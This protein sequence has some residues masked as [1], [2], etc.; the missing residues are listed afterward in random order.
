MGRGKQP[1]IP[2]LG[3]AQGTLEACYGVLRVDPYLPYLWRLLRPGRG[4]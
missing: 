3:R 2:L 1:R 4:P